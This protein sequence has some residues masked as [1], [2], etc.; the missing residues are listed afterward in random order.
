[1]RKLLFGLFTVVSIAIAGTAKAAEA[2]HPEARD[3]SWQGVFGTFDQAALQRGLQVYLE[4][5][6]VCHSLDYVA[7]RN[8]T[9]LGYSEEQ[10][11]AFAAEYEVED[12]PNEDGEMYSRPARPSDQF[13][14]PFPNDQAARASNNGAMPPD[15]SLIVEA[16]QGGADYLY[17]LLIGYVEPP[18]GVE[19]LE[20]MTF[21]TYFPSQQIAMPLPLYEDGVEYADGTPASV[22]QMAKDVSA[23]LTWTAEPYLEERKSLGLKALLFL[24][25][26]T[27]ML[28]AVKRKVWADV[29]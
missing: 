29:K 14:R 5:C 28:I 23:F 18:E 27:A 26:F 8:L 9:A 19:L 13:A 4:V 20:G 17:G 25:V 1:M 11:K 3:W 22:E 2:P 6:A 24:L 15:L 16:R 7:Y 21:N 12:G 10:V